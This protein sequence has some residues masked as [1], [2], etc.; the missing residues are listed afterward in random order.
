M[1]L[2]SGKYLILGILVTLTAVIV[3]V[4][5]NELG[6]PDPVR[7]SNCAGGGPPP[8]A[9]L[10]ARDAPL[11]RGNARGPEGTPGAY[12]HQASSGR[13]PLGGTR[14]TVWPPN[15]RSPVAFSTRPV[16]PASVSSRLQRGHSG[17]ISRRQEPSIA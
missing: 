10:A 8:R 13:I 4:T 17:R 3:R 7:L 9:S 11:L 12:S 2:E 15:Q 14:P 5:K 6:R 1:R 16:L